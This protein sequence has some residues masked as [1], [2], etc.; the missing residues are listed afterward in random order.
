MNKNTKVAS[1]LLKK[2]VIV[3]NEATKIHTYFLDDLNEQLKNL[4]E[5][6]LPFGGVAVI[7]PEILSKHFPL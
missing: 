6:Y 2:E 4:K 7:Y 3:I 1:D 5:K